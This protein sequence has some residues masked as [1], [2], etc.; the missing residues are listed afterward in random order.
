[1]EANSVA[2]HR[3]DVVL[4]SAPECFE[5]LH[6]PEVEQYLD[7]L[8]PIVLEPLDRDAARAMI[9]QPLYEQGVSV[10][11]GGANDIIALTGGHPYYIIIFLQ[12]VARL[13]NAK[14]SKWELT[15]KDISV[16]TQRVLRHPLCFHGAV[17][18]PGGDESQL[19]CLDAI[20][21]LG[22]TPNDRVAFGDIAARTGMPHHALEATLQRLVDYRLLDKRVSPGGPDRY[23]FA[24]PLVR[25]WVR[26]TGRAELGHRTPALAAS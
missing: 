21:R 24:I 14:P 22:V 7:R 8:D 9:V 6:S 3:L 4:V 20:A 25:A 23:R 11:A 19:V 2:G 15:E 17:N 16:C 13:L 18:E 10:A 12:E 5:L 1:M 26:R